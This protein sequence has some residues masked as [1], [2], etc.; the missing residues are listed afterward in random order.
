MTWEAR[1]PSTRCT[2]PDWLLRYVIVARAVAR[3]KMCS[4]VRTKMNVTQVPSPACTDDARALAHTHSY[5][6]LLLLAWAHHQHT[7]TRFPTWRNTLNGRRNR[8]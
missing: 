2:A 1:R 4:G 5:T 3:C 7:H 6:T 8:L